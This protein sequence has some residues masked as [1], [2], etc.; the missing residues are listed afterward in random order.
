MLHPGKLEGT[1]RKPLGL[2]YWGRSAQK[3]AKTAEA[4]A[5]R[6]ADGGIFLLDVTSQRLIDSKGMTFAAPG[7]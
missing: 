1:S 4:I 2:S 5:P 3:L 7:E 6:Q